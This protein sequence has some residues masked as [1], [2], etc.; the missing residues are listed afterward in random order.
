[1]TG[2][3]RGIRAARNIGAN[4][5]ILQES[6]VLAVPHGE[7]DPRVFFFLAGEGVGNHPAFAQ[8]RTGEQEVYER[9]GHSSASS[10][11]LTRGCSE[12][13]CV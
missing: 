4:E 8:C 6:P 11:G 7:T 1:M 12:Y 13:E 2:K 3:G 5:I 9:I 10:D